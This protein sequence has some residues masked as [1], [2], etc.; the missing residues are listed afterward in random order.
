M[1]INQ[2]LCLQFFHENLTVVTVKDQE[3]MIKM[4]NS[5]HYLSES[6]ICI[7]QQTILMGTIIS[8]INNTKDQNRIINMI[9]NWDL[10]KIHIIIIPI[11]SYINFILNVIKE[12][13][14]LVKNKINYF[15]LKSD[16]MYYSCR[17]QTNKNLQFFFYIIEWSPFSACCWINLK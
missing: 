16:S 3:K 7:Y 6:T 15:C 14:V 4:E 5:F 17:V 9:L 1:E 13:D 8:Q 12:S 11:R 2:V 10:I